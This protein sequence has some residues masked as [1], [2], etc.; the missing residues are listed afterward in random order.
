[1]LK[2]IVCTLWRVLLTILL[3]ELIIASLVSI[4][5]AFYSIIVAL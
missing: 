3:V 1:M 5:F 2:K 4:G